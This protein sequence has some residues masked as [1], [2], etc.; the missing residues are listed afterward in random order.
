MENGS[1][2]LMQLRSILSD[3]QA[4]TVQF[5]P[6]LEYCQKCK[7][8]LWHYLLGGG[9]GGAI[10]TRQASV[11]TTKLDYCIIRETEKKQNSDCHS[12]S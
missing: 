4:T 5:I 7:L 6:A 2:L 8:K 3:S 11:W 9:G 12:R 10:A 1:D